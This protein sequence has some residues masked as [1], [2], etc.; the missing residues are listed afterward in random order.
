[1]GQ[2]AFVFPGQGSQEVG[3][4]GDLLAVHEQV[5]ETFAEAS[6]VLG[7]DLR[8]LI[9]EGPEEQ[10][11]QTEFTQPAILTSS[12]AIWRLFQSAG[13]ST[14]DVVAGHSLGEYSALVAASVI[15]FPDAVKLVQ[16]RGQFMQTAVPVG[17][18]S[19]AAILGLEDD[20]V[21]GICDMRRA[22][23]TAWVVDNQV[24][25][26]ERCGFHVTDPPDAEYEAPWPAVTFMRAAYQTTD[27]ED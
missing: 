17:E 2:T 6:E 14:P 12:V 27:T 26:F 20:Q 9:S 7:Y 21:I 13:T 11:T 15:A 3:M 24:L 19:M 23:L 5:A 25:F 18:G 10:L 4:L 8:K 22:D 1:M 16:K